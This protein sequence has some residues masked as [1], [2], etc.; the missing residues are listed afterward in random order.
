MFRLDLS[1]FQFRLLK[2]SL[3]LMVH[4]KEMNLFSFELF[5]WT[6]FNIIIAT[7]IH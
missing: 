6:P 5:T 4:W 3:F 1:T 7:V 2:N